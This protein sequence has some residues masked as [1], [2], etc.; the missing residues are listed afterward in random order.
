[1][2]WA[3][4]IFVEAQRHEALTTYPASSVPRTAPPALVDAERKADFEEAGAHYVSSYFLTF[5][6]SFPQPRKPR[7]PSPGS[8][9][10][11]NVR[12]SI[13]T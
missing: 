12:A 6:L 10:A 7:A 13:R 9:K 4:A 11:A 5:S 8:T 1:L 2:A 3:G